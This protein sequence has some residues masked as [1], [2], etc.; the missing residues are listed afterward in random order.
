MATRFFLMTRGRTGSS[1]VIDELN[2]ADNVCAMQEMFTIW[3]F[4]SQPAALVHYPEFLPFNAWNANRKGI[5]KF[6]GRIFGE[7]S[8]ANAYLEELEG[9]LGGRNVGAYGFKVLSNHFDERP[10]LCE[11]LKR[12]GYV[13]IYLTRS[14]GRQVLSGM[15]AA[16]RGVYNTKDPFEDRKSYEIDVNLF[17]QFVNW[18]R[19][20]VEND[21]ATLAKNGFHF[22][23][24]TYED[25]LAE[26][27]AFYNKISRHLGMSMMVPGKSDF[28]IMIKSLADT[29]ANYNEVAAKA[30]ELDVEIDVS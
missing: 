6:V 13:G 18:E 21:C 7:P 29:I 5:S 22:T 15:V 20:C 23:V 8:Q 4:A 2:R 12:R 17:E 1:A 11:L 19:L 27:E 10:Y 25:F 16:Q 3:D 26:R 24:V 14:I 9:F 30:A 28:Q